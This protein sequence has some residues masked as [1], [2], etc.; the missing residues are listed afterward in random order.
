MSLYTHKVA[1]EDA[2]RAGLELAQLLGAFGG[3]ATLTTQCLSRPLFW[4]GYPSLALETRHH[5]C[6]PR[7]RFLSLCKLR[8]LRHAQI[9]LIST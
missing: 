7:V 3:R 8:M 1:Q 9:L 4:I 5:D 6:K 2:C